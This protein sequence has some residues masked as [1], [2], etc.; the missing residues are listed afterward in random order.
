MAGD[1]SRSTFNRVKHYAGV[2]MQQGRVQVDADWNEQLALQLHRTWT[3]TRDLIGLCGS[4]QCGSGF[5]ISPAPGSGDLFIHPGRFYVHGLLCELDPQAVPAWLPS[6]LSSP[7]ASRQFQPMPAGRTLSAVM[8]QRS[9][10]QMTERRIADSLSDRVVCVPSRKIDDRDLAPGDWVEVFSA[11]GDSV[12][13]QVQQVDQAATPDDPDF[14]VPSYYPLI[15]DTSLHSLANAGPLSLRR[16]VTFTTQ[17]FL[18]SPWEDVVESSP[19]GGPAALQLP[20]GDYLVALEAWQR[21]IDAIQDAHIRE[22]ALGG[23]DTCARLQTVWQVHVLPWAG[24]SSPPGPSLPSPLPSPPSPLDCCSDFPG[25]DACKAAT[26]TT[27][28]M[29]A[30]APPPGNNVPPCQLPPSAGYLGLAN[31]LYRVEIFQAGQFNDAATFVWSRDNAMVETPI[32]CADASGNVYVSSLGTDDL[33]SFNLNDWVEIVDDDAD[34][35]GQPRFLAQISQH[36]GSPAQPPCASAGVQACQLTLQPGAPLRL[37]DKAN[38]RLRRWDMTDG[39]VAL[40]GSLNPIGVP[41]VPGWIE[42]ENNIQVNFSDGFYAGRSYWQIP[43]RTATADIEWPPFDVPNTNPVPQPPLGPDHFFCRLALLS[44][45][46]GEIQVQEDCRSTFP[47][48][49][50][51]CAQMEQALEERDALHRLQNRTLHGSGVVCGLAVTCPGPA[52]NKTSVNV[53]AGYALDCDGYDLI[54]ADAKSVDLASIVDLSPPTSPLSSLLGTLPDGEYELLLERSGPSARVCQGQASTSP[55]CDPCSSPR[56]ASAA[57]TG[58]PTQFRAIACQKETFANRVLDG[59]LLK[60][61]YTRC[62]Q[63]AVT[64][65]QNSW[66]NTSISGSN[67]ITQA[68]ALLSALTNLFIEIAEPALTADVYISASEAQLLQAFYSFV[69]GEIGDCTNCSLT[70]NLPAFPAY[71]LSQPMYTLYGKGYMSRMRVAQNGQYAVACGKGPSLHIYDIASGLLVSDVTPPIPG[72]PSGWTVNDV[73]FLAEGAFCAIATGVN[74][75]THAADSLVAIGRIS[76]GAVTWTTQG[77]AGARAFLTLA[78][79]PIQPGVVFAAAQGAGIYAITVTGTIAATQI[80]RFNAIGHL[81]CNSR[82]LY[83]TAAVTNQNGGISYEVLRYGAQPGAVA[84]DANMVFALD[85]LTMNL[86]DDLAVGSFSNAAADQ[87]SEAVFVSGYSSATS[88]KHLLLFNGSEKGQQ[89]GQIDLTENTTVRL[90]V[91]PYGTMLFVS[92]ESS[93]RMATVAAGANGLSITPYAPV[94]L[95]PT[96]MAFAVAQDHFFVYTLNCTANTIST[97]SADTLAFSDNQKLEQY[98]VQAIRAF[99][100]LAEAYVQDLKDCFCRLLLPICH[101]CPDDAPQ[102]KGVAL[103]CITI[104][105]GAVEKICNLEKRKTVKSFS[106]VDYWLSAIPIIPLIKELVAELCCLTLPGLLN[107]ALTPAPAGT[108]PSS[109]LSFMG[110]KVGGIS[111]ESL[112]YAFTQIGKLNLSSLP[113]ALLKRIAPIGNLTLDSVVSPLRPPSPQAAAVPISQINGMAIDQA[114]AALQAGNVQVIATEAYN[115]ATFAQN[116]SSYISAP[117]AVPPGSSLTLA[118]DS[119][120][121]VRYYVPTAP[122]VQQLGAAVQTNQAAVETQLN[123]AAQVTQQL[124]ARVTAVEIAQSP[125]ANN[126]QSLQSTISSLQTQFDGMQATHASELASRDQQ[127]AQLTAATQQMQTKLSAIDSLSAQLQAL[128]SRLPPSLKG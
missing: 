30:Q 85:S 54:L 22:V 114:R 48:L 65:F 127:I 41:I 108:A 47:P 109:G 31:Q 105:N 39:Q 118:V 66:V 67:Q 92:L 23:P 100:A 34:L 63:P 71:P 28:L 57:P 11:A 83:G 111:G 81:V 82:F 8:R 84:Q 104:R 14:L 46:G 37:Q 35:Q 6:S 97:I 58:V 61:F 95:N 1:F 113:A 33:H 76:A 20:D 87:V 3:E 4:P 19:R 38:L 32:V 40:D 102:G 89:A 15:L 107:N 25:F 5:A 59:T 60:D 52:L 106:T 74:T 51:I 2:L 9:V 99:I 103:A 55:P 75:Q 77:S 69:L 53:E 120:N 12:Q 123:A 73:A 42:L 117:A 79:S 49:N 86:T 116:V 119:G 68:Q 45:T 70:D 112:R 93:S 128:Q 101:S 21:E 96:A 50:S 80:A 16:M 62:V 56:A 98:R 36:P 29:N 26:R 91:H 18:L 122:A 94:E 27:G 44:V 64:A 17:P 126:I 72:D 90:A 110:Y 121:T 7:P 88:T 115:P 10:L 24:E 78:T 124:Q 43:A 13:A 125:N